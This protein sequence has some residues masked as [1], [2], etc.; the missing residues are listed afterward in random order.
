MEVLLARQPIPTD[1][2]TASSR[3][4]CA[5]GLVQVGV[6]I[7]MLFLTGFGAVPFLFA[8]HVDL[9]WRAPLVAL[10]GFIVASF[11]GSLML[12]S[13]SIGSNMRETR[14]S[15]VDGVVA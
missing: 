11:F 6:W 13:G 9:P 7:S 4:S 8:A 10:P 5:T 1:P 12:G 2:R 14:S 3:A 15:C